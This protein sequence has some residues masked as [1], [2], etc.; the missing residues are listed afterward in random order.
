MLCTAVLI[1]LYKRH[2]LF[3]HILWR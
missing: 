3:L 1:L 2:A